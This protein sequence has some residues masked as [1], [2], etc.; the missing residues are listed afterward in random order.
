M[1][2]A[3]AHL[4]RASVAIGHSGH[5]KV[6][7]EIVHENVFAVLGL[8]TC[9]HLQDSVY[10]CSH[11]GPQPTDDDASAGEAAE[12]DSAVGL[13]QVSDGTGDHIAGLANVA[14]VHNCLDSAVGPRT[15]LDSPVLF[16]SEAVSYPA[17]IHHIP[18][19]CTDRCSLGAALA[20]RSHPASEQLVAGNC[21]LAE[22]ADM[23]HSD[24][25]SCL[26]LVRT[27]L[28]MSPS[29]PC[30]APFSST[31]L[32]AG[33]QAVANL[34]QQQR[35]ANRSGR[36]GNGLFAE[37]DQTA[38]NVR[39]AAQRQVQRFSRVRSGQKVLQILLPLRL[40]VLPRTLLFQIDGISSHKPE[41]CAVKAT[42]P[43][44]SSSLLS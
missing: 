37:R 29:L 42:K 13:A 33:Y 15:G 39:G 8:H 16:A 41:A 20:I 43:R 6:V 12:Q 10:F 18:G 19:R 23:P 21:N 35:K 4:Q 38:A 3:V 36:K 28:A 17:D 1:P 5:G 44:A 32:L 26:S 25:K 34:E 24:C 31:Q 40:R 9:E 27:S 14:V 7:H 11:T 30:A 2:S 22:E